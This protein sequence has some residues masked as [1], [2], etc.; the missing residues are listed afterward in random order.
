MSYEDMPTRLVALVREFEELSSAERGDA[1]GQALKT[2]I[3]LA[4]L[5][6]SFFGGY[7]GMKRLHDAAEQLVGND[8]S[9]G[10]RLNYMW[11]GVGGCWSS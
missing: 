6:A 2:Q 4:G 5:C 10:F 11:D 3:R 9:I 7:D 8:N 1:E